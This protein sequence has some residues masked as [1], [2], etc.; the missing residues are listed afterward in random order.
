[1]GHNGC[2]SMPATAVGS[3]WSTRLEV[4]PEGEGVGVFIPQLCQ[5]L[6]ECPHSWITSSS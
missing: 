6:S 5:A 3:C 2:V 4:T 1:M